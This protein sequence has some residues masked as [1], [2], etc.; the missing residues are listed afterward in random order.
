MANLSIKNVPEAVAEQLRQRAKQH[1][2]SLQGELMVILE[3]A[4]RTRAGTKTIDEVYE[5]LKQLG[6]VPTS[7]DSLTILRQLR[8]A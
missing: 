6:P 4:A 2:R 7:P 1:H 8:D 5:E 3:D